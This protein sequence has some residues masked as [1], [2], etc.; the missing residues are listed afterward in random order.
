MEVVHKSPV[1]CVRAEG[2]GVKPRFV[3][4]SRETSQPPPEPDQLDE[5]Q[6]CGVSRI[7]Y[8]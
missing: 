6:K 1:P 5:P 7:L 2:K 4:S 3:I 8:I